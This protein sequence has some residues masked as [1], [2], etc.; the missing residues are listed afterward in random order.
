MKVNTK[1]VR[2]NYKAS[3]IESGS[4]TTIDRSIT[5]KLK[6]YIAIA[7]DELLQQFNSHPVTQ[8]IDM[9]P[10]GSNIS[11]TLSGYGCLFS[12]IGFDSGDNPTDIIRRKIKNIQLRIYQKGSKVDYKIIAPSIEN[13]Y[14]DTPLPWAKGRSWVRGIEHGLP[15]IAQY[16]HSKE[17]SSC[18]RSGTGLLIKEPKTFA[19]KSHIRRFKNTPYVTMMLRDFDEKM[20]SYIN[21]ILKS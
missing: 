7:K 18:S 11:G 6:D 20:K 9:G 8:E 14:R 4:L 13:I 10:N 19:L 21:F 17:I 12:F 15:N 16:K 3:I 1:S 2:I 5:P